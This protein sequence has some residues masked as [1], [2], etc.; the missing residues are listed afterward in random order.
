MIADAVPHDERS[1]QRR[2]SRQA[3]PASHAHMIAVLSGRRLP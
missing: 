1:L 3:A 2:L